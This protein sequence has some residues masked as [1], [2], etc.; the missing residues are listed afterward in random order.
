MW[1]CQSKFDLADPLKERLKSM[2]DLRRSQFT[3]E[4]INGQGVECVDILSKI[5]LREIDVSFHHVNYNRA[6]CYDVSM[7]GFFIETD[8]AANDICT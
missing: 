5:V 8:I 2:S 7:L 6:P 4:E 1:E 3:T